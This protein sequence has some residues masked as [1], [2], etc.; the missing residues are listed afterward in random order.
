MALLA[1]ADAAETVAPAAAFGHL[2]RAFELWDDAAE[3]AAQASRRDRLWQAA[4]LAS[5]TAGNQR[6]LELAR[7]AFQEGPPRPG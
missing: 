5:V 6:A 7:S 1:A 3:S 2:E 4:E